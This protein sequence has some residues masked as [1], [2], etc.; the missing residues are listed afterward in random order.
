LTLGVGLI[1]AFLALIIFALRL[2][3]LITHPHTLNDL[4]T[5]YILFYGLAE[6]DLFGT[7]LFTS[8]IF[9]RI[10]LQDGALKGFSS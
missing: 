4:M 7:P 6:V 10:A 5:L 8:L 9:F 3:T 2:K 1:G